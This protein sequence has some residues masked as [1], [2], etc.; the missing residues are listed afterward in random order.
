MTLFTA[1]ITGDFRH[2]DGASIHVGGFK[3]VGR[4]RLLILRLVSWWPLSS[5]KSQ[6]VEVRQLGSDVLKGAFVAD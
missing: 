2:I 4:W 1:V 5:G 3:G 6:G